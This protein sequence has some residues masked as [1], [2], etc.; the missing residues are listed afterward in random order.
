MI[1]KIKDFLLEFFKNKLLEKHKFKPSSLILREGTRTL[2]E[3]DSNYYNTE[4]DPVTIVRAYPLGTQLMGISKHEIL[5][6]KEY[7]SMP[8][9]GL[10]I[11]AHDN[12]IF[13]KTKKD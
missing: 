8:D 1:Q 6:F 2:Y 11:T 4:M 9:E 5:E 3:V 12:A 10:A 13:G 7:R